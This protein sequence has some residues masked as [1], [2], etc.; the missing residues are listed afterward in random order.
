MMRFPS[1]WLAIFKPKRIRR[2][3]GETVADANSR[4]FRELEAS[5]LRMGLSPK[6]ATSAAKRDANG[7]ISI[8]VTRELSAVATCN[9]SAKRTGVRRPTMSRDVQFRRHAEITAGFPKAGLPYEE[10]S[11]RH[12]KKPRRNCPSGANIS[13]ECRYCWLLSQVSTS[14]FT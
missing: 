12:R 13:V 3:R 7:I 8:E 11:R 14:F 1:S 10:Q 4:H 5:Y 6:A 9:F 2:R